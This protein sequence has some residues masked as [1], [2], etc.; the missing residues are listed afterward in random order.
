MTIKASVAGNLGGDATL[1]HLQDGTPILDFSIGAQGDKNR[2]TGEKTTQWVRC[3]MWGKRGESLAQYLT[4][5]RY[6][7]AFGS[8]T[9][10]SF[11]T[12]EGQARTSLEL[13]IDDV[14]MGPSP[15][16]R[17]DGQQPQAPQQRQAP[18][19]PQAQQT[20]YRPAPPQ[21]GYQQQ[22]APQGQQRRAN[23]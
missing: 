14:A 23:F 12:K 6:V 1:R 16:P 15:A 7:V 9:Q 5:G 20:Q 21:Q 2:E 10:Q 18:P 22:A 17:E 3:S 4:K 13:K 19:Q 11:T 8:L